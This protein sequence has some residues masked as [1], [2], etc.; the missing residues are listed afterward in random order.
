M[1]K[2][3]YIER[4]KQ[5]AFNI[6]NSF[7]D[8]VRNKDITRIGYRVYDGHY[9]GVSGSIGQQEDA[10]LEKDA[11][12]NL[13]LK[14]PY[15]APVSSNVQLHV[16]HVED[17]I[18]S[19]KVLEDL[20]EMMAHLRTHFADFSIS[21]KLII[22]EQEVSLLNDKN[23]T[24]TY[25]DKAFILSFIAR[26]QSSTSI[27]DTGV[28]GLWRTWDK[29]TLLEEITRNLTAYRKLVPLPDKTKMPIIFVKE[30][31]LLLISK[32]LLELDGNKMGSG[33]S[34]FKDCIGQKKFNE[35][36]S[37]YQDNSIENFTPFFDA[38]GVINPDFRYPLIEDGKLM[39]AYTDKQTA[40]KFN[41][42]LTGSASA[43]YDGV[44]T[45]GAPSISIG[46]SHKTL[47]ELLK[48][49]LGLAVILAS[50]GDYTPEG[51][52]ATPVQ[53]AML[54]DGETFL[55]RVPEFE[56][57][58]NLYTMFGEDYIG[59]SKDKPFSGSNTLVINMK[60]K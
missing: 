26:E 31:Q 7:I 55:G 42:P 29:S 56:L 40:Q 49:Q 33:A 11:I 18:S 17:T 50:G 24:L 15:N 16:S 48:G 44:P 8:S 43:T 58:G 57:S 30:D 6:T 13:S 28:S 38:E 2:E 23:L 39:A 45:L 46:S 54:T 14:I 21:N 9:I 32:F 19:E 36:F 34:L 3:K 27:F 47:K 35:H 60:I 10:I 53:L 20:E 22:E 5:T 52:F 12:A 4:T 59:C 51:N 41:L 25:V 37:L 1:I